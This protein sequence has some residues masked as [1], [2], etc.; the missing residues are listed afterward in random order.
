LHE[1]IIIYENFIQIKYF[2]QLKKHFDNMIISIKHDIRQILQNYLL[3]AAKFEHDSA[4]FSSLFSSLFSC[5]A[6]I[7]R[8]SSLK[9]IKIMLKP[10]R[11]F[12]IVT[13]VQNDELSC[14]AIALRHEMCRK[15]IDNRFKEKRTMKDFSKNRQLFIDQ[16]KAIILEF[17]NDLIDLRF[18]LE[19]Y[20]IEEKIIL[21][22]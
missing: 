21:L 1:K 18:F 20:M 12:L 16:E 4:A 19:L 10:K 14:H 8:F 6:S 9:K 22:L 7:L 13:I 15:I 5:L 2:D 11:I 3:L 17:V